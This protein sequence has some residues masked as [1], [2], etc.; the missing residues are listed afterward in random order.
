M[1]ISSDQMLSRYDAGEGWREV[2]SP[3]P[4]SLVDARLQLHWAAQVVAAVGHNLLPAR[5][6][7][8]HT[9]LQWVDGP[10]MMI[11]HAVSGTRHVQAALHPARLALR[12]LA[13]EN[14]SVLEEL[15]LS[16][17]SLD[18]A[19]QWMG[20]A[21]ARH[22]GRPEARKLERR[23]YEMPN[24]PVGRGARF[25]DRDRS[26][27]GE[28]ARWFGNGSRVMRTIVRARREAHTVRIWPHHFDIGTIIPLLGPVGEEPTVGVGL[29]PG[30][31][32]YPEPYFYV[33]AWPAPE[34]EA[35]P[36]LPGMASWHTQDWTG[37]VLLGT[38]CALAG[39]GEA[40]SAMVA[41]FIESAVPA[42]ITLLS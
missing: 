22:S 1:S 15:Y 37:A 5:P 18:Q 31:G 21:V 19:Y 40:Q 35:L 11:G 36:T 10:G 34:E 42:A 8:S 6:D 26:A 24:H 14:G 27:L 17:S 28:L 13:A 33:N 20:E 16:G 25:S 3:I 12:L 30:D 2:G 32:Y 9:A 38:Y 4:T 7:D 39:R 29:S 23:D 41:R